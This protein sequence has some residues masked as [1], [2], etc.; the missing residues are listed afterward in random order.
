MGLALLQF[1][2]QKHT[3]R[4]RFLQEIRIEEIQ[5]VLLYFCAALT[6]THLEQSRKWYVI[7]RTQFY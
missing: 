4:E 2:Q 6:F 3:H 7:I 1:E 5:A